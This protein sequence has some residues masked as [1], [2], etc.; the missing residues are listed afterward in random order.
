MTAAAAAMAV[1]R[2]LL[3]WMT[4]MRW[5]AMEGRRGGWIETWPGRAL[6]GVD[7]S[8]LD[9]SFTV[10]VIDGHWKSPLVVRC[11][12]VRTDSCPLSL[13]LLLVVVAVVV[14]ALARYAHWNVRESVYNDEGN[15]LSIHA[16][17]HPSSQPFRRGGWLISENTNNGISSWC[18][19]T[20]HVFGDTKSASKIS[21][22]CP[23][24]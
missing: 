5:R 10:T 13:S 1:G 8:L 7:D 17:I 2:L 3:A 19:V 16:S 21:P 9:G 15:D 14:V 18:R 6:A 11:C 24:E 12:G 4:A 22:I 20:L 23:A